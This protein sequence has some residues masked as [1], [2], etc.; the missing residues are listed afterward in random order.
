MTTHA[1]VE[2][3]LLRLERWI[4]KHADTFTVLDMARGTGLSR[5]QVYGCR[6]KLLG[7]EV[8]QEAELTYITP[9]TVEQR[10]RRGVRN[11]SGSGG[12]R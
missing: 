1:E 10:Y 8:L 6:R 2:K 4:S 5:N 7:R 12:E 11:D 9:G 3:N